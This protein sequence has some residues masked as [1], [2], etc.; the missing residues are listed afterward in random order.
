MNRASHLAK[1]GLPQVL[2]CCVNKPL[3]VALEATDYR[4]FFTQ[5]GVFMSGATNEAQL[6]FVK[7]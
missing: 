4:L 6:R 1:Y 5:H 2:P 3:P 7:H